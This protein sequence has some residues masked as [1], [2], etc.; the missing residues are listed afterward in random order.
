MD[1]LVAFLRARLDEEAE[2]ARAT[3][4]GEWVWSREFVTPPGDHH[5]TVGPLE[6]GDAWFIARHSPARVLAEVDA[7]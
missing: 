3:T 5:R 4:Q 2:E 7:K 1:D 6:P